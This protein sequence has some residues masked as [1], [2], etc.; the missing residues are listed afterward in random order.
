MSTATEK[1]VSV[2][3]V[4]KKSTPNMNVYECKDLAVM[5]SLYVH[6]SFSEG[7]KKIKVTVEI[8]G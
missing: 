7:A 4:Y 6:K 5:T 1:T 2:E 8:I 3:M